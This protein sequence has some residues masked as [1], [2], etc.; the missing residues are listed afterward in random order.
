MTTL[1]R[2]LAALWLQLFRLLI[3][4]DQL[5]NVLIGGKPDETISSRAGK[6]RLRGSFFWSVAADCI[7]LIFLPFESNH[8]YNSI[9]WDE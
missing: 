2:V 4:I 1:K 5:A 8:C 6:G 3:S 7:D 9:E